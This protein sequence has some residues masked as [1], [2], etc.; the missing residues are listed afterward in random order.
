MRKTILND[1]V[2][3][4]S[5]GWLD[6]STACVEVS[7]EDP[8]HP[9]ERALGGIPGSGWRASRPGKQMLRLTFDRRQRISRIQV[10]FEEHEVERSQEFAISWSSRPGAASREALR[11]QW[12]FH[13]GAAVEAEEYA[14]DLEEVYCLQLEIDP[15]RDRNTARASLKGLRLA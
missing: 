13:S 12:N 9:I 15:D 2:N 11:Q 3:T 7:S 4:S 14:V 1:A 6:L 8:A 10:E 5:A